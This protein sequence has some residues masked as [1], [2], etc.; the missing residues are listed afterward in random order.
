MSR[1]ITLIF[2]LFPKYPSFQLFVALSLAMFLCILTTPNLIRFF[3]KKNI[4][5]IVRTD[6]PEPHL[7]KQ[8]TPTMGGI[9][10][11][12]SAVFAWAVVSV[13]RGFSVRG[14]LI[15]GLIVA[16]GLIG[17]VDDYLKT[18]RRRSLGL[19]AR[20]KLILQLF[21]S[22]I[23]SYVAINYAGLPTYVE[24]PLTGY[25]I[26]L[27]MFYPLF[28]YLIIAATTN[29]VNLTDGLDGLAAGTVAI[30]SAALA[31][32]A[33]RE[34]MPDVAFFAAAI[35]GS[36]AGF[37]WWNA[38]PARIF[39]GDTGSLSLGGAIAA[40]SILTKTELFLP[41]IGGIFVIEGL[42]VILQVLSFRLFKKRIF[43]MAPIHHHFEML[44][45][46]E[47]QTMIRFWILAGF[48]AGLGFALFFTGGL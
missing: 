9:T 15:L 3:K 34:K 10:I 14:L 21:V 44:G 23:F 6:G 8:G 43:K 5:Q 39:M 22:L 27:G 40:I 16:C 42:S 7:K 31:A 41:L 32:I 17:L 19:K 13:T 18:A 12:L 48:L 4:G 33:F 46:S 38:N 2:S 1:V 45:W 47:T 37:L 30:A 28:V 29:T 36:A 26:E 24:L 11:I 20:H 25:V 35:A